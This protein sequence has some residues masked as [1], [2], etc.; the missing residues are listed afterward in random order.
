MLIPAMDAVQSSRVGVIGGEGY[1]I[2]AVLHD[3]KVPER[4]HGGA[5]KQARLLAYRADTP[6]CFESVI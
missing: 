3:Q 5:W 2:A 6:I 1:N 4:N